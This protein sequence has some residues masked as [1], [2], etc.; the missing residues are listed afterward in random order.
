[1]IAKSSSLFEHAIVFTSGASNKSVF[2]VLLS[3]SEDRNGQRLCEAANFSA[4]VPCV[5]AV[6]KIMLENQ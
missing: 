3:S 6:G 5:C 4:L 2:N 1:M